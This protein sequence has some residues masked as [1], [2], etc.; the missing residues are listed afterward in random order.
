MSQVAPS[1]SLRQREPRVRDKE[2]LARV[3]KLF[4]LPCYMR[5]VK[6]WPVQVAH[7]RMSLPE[8][9]WREFGKSEKPHDWRTFPAC[10]RCHLDGPDAQHRS[11][12]AAWW[13]RLDVYPPAFCAAL[14][15][16][17]GKRDPGMAVLRRAAAGEFPWPTKT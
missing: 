15:E 14:Q 13:R 16:A 3:A 10:P 2:H 11:N 12:E 5:G 17:F 6:T 4:C 7:I 9:G 8:A 1:G